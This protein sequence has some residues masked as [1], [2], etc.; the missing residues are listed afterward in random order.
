MR[1]RLALAMMNFVAIG[2][3]LSTLAAAGVWSPAP[4]PP[5]PAGQHGGEHVVREGRRVVIVE[6]EREH[7]L[8]PGNGVK[9]THVLPRDALDGREGEGE[10]K[11]T[12]MARGVVSDVADRA[13]DAAEGGMERLSDAK[14]S[15]TGK[16]FG[17]VKRCK[18]RL[19]G[20]ARKAEEGAKERASAVEH[21]TEDA[22]RGAEEALSRAKE[23][24]EGKVFDAA[25][26]VKETAMGAKDKFSEAA[27]KAKEKTSQ[28]QHG[29]AES[30]KSA[31]DKV[32]HA[33][34]YA[35]ESAK[36]RAMDAKDRVSDIT[37]R[38][39]QYTEDAA[40]S[41]AR[42]AAQAEEAVKAKAGEAASNL[43]DIARRA[44]DVV[45]DAAAYLLGGPR[46]AARTATTVMH[47]LGFATAYGA[48][49]WVTF[50]SSYVLAAALPRQQLGVV[51]S[52]L[53][54]VYFRAVAYG[55][56]LA[57]A[58][59]LLGRERSSLAARAQSLNLLT[60]L[61]LVLAN[62]LLLEPK[63]TKVM[64][65]RMK[66]EKEE[67][68]GRDMADIVD[69]PVVTVATGNTATTTTV[70]TA[71]KPADGAA[72][73]ISMTGK[74][75]PAPADAQASKSRV[76]RLNQRL[77]KLNGYSSLCNVLCLMALTWHLVHLA[78]R[79]QMGSA[80]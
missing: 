2:L 27:G 22:V 57:L 30:V 68:R 10:G 31:K 38:A 3:V 70:P 63:A 16:V 20:A 35:G 32:S 43:S 77:K 5:S 6:Y 39:E 54:P 12:D 33:A 64:F 50:V 78:R 52:K 41:A 24:A 45:S 21:G 4:T 58:A 80:C 48:S 53:F 44:R 47:L 40:G 26:Q 15:A 8:Y 46:E 73:G 62:M 36:E 65:D 71:L 67:G 60:A 13:A 56:G 72:P 29:A 19:C 79:L 37:E 17:A 23:S 51:Q 9:E 28:V 11:I 55:V 34:R 61:A 66:V 49:V 14:E 59:H 76:V 74:P 1:R 42:K 7:P 25:S 75:A 18:D 69:P